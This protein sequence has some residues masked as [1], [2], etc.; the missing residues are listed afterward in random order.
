MTTA[1]HASLGLKLL[2]VAATGIAA[3][4]HAGARSRAV[5]A[6]GGAVALLSGLGAV[7][8]G[9]QLSGAT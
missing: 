5:L 7:F 4:F 2:L 1:W 3:A 6:A 8:V 9:L